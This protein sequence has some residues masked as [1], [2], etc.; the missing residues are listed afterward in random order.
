MAASPA[1]TGD[2]LVSDLVAPGVP[3]ESSRSVRAGLCCSRIGPE[4]PRDPAMMEMMEGD[5][6]DKVEDVSSV[7]DFD[8]ITGNIPATK[9]EITVSCR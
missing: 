7:Y 1:H 4:P 8:P 3:A 9:V 6:M 5:V 2:P